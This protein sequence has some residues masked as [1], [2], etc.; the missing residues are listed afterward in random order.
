MNDFLLDF[1]KFVGW[2]IQRF[3]EKD[4][5]GWRGADAIY[6]EDY[7]ARA[8]KNITEGDHIDACNLCFLAEW[9]RARGKVR[10]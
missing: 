6:E 1:L 3:M 4:K 10:S 7:A 9:A 5:D 8:V 2:Q